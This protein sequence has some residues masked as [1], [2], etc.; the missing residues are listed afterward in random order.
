MEGENNKN[1]IS[2]RDY[3]DNRFTELKNYMDI[4]FNS[5]EK[6]TCLA[7]E[8][9][10]ARLENMNEFRNS[11]K[12][13]TANFITRTEHESL[14]QKYDSDIRVLRETQAEAR[15]KASIQSVYV[16][17]A[18]AFIGIIMGILGLLFRF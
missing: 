7:Q 10:N 6:S 4:K 14:I 13:Q 15:G 17:Y 2:L 18:I 1:S 11:L 8:N 12:D 9:L 5:I 16:G 3:F